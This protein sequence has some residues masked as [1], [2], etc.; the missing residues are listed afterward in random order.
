MYSRYTDIITLH[1]VCTSGVCEVFLVDKAKTHRGGGGDG[2]LGH[3]SPISTG[4]LHP[5]TLP[6]RRFVPDNGEY[7][8]VRL[9]SYVLSENRLNACV[10]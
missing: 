7:I 1:T 2:V 8:L 6:V 9:P 10:R 4:T 3:L 5:C